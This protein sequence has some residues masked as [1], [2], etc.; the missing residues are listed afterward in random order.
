MHVFCMKRDGKKR[1]DLT[2]RIILSNCQKRRASGRLRP[3]V[4]LPL[5]GPQT[6]RRSSLIAHS[7]TATPLL[8]TFR[9]NRNKRTMKQKHVLKVINGRSLKIPK[10]GNQSK[11]DQ[12][13]ETIQL[14]IAIFHAKSRGGEIRLE[15]R[16][17]SVF[18]PNLQCQ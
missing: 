17:R 7:F 12:I 9:S 8:L 16:H 13:S 1:S 10:G 6:P 15:L 5:S 2:T 18:F 14:E 11:N 4:P 3:L